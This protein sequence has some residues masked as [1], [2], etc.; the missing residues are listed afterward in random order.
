MIIDTIMGWII[1]FINWVIG[2]L[3]EIPT[4]IPG[5]SE[6]EGF[7]ELCSNV[8]FFLPLNIM[9]ACITIIISV[10]IAMNSFWVINWIVKRVR[11]G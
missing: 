10:H 7:A 4:Y 5:V 3:P 8:A 9:A 11:G 1:D 2:L 6:L